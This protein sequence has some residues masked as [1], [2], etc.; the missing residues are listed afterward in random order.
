MK[1]TSCP[2]IPF[3]FFGHTDRRLHT[4]RKLSC[5]EPSVI[6]FDPADPERAFCRAELPKGC[7]EPLTDVDHDAAGA[8]TMPA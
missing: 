3:P 8:G 7:L 1:V 4:I 5:S 2:P 6:V